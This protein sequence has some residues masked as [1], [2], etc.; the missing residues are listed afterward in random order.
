MRRAALI[1]AVLALALVAG[2]CSSSSLSTTPTG[3]PCT[4]YKSY[5]SSDGCFYFI[6]NGTAVACQFGK[7]DPCQ[8]TKGDF[9]D[10]YD[11]KTYVGGNHNLASFSLTA[12]ATPELCSPK[13]TYDNL[14]NSGQAWQVVN[15]QEDQNTTQQTITIRFSSTSA[16]TISTSASVNVTANADAALGVVFVSV[17]AQINASV[18]RTASTVVGNEVTVTIPAGMTAYGIYGVKVQVTGG[19]LYQSNSCG[20]AK[21]NYGDVQTY[22]PIAPGWCVWLSGQ[23]P[24]RV[25]PGT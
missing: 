7:T 16:T 18:T 10:Y 20:T 22:V 25:L 11:G 5:G 23:T 1:L 17:R 15:Q 21:P 8:N 14:A 24:C 9:Y 2:G 19:H 6:K 12:V 3:Y 4:L 13:F